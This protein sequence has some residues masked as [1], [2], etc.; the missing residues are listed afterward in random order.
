[1][2]LPA[3]LDTTLASAISAW[4]EGSRLDAIRRLTQALRLAEKLRFI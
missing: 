3:R 1:M 4:D 2:R